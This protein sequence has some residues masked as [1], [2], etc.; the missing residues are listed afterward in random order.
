[1]INLK[2]IISS[3]VYRKIIVEVCR[4]SKI[5]LCEEYSIG[6]NK[7]DNNIIEKSG[8]AIEIIENTLKIEN[9]NFIKFCILKITKKEIQEE[10][11]EYAEGEELDGEEKSIFISSSGYSQG[12]LIRYLIEYYYLK[13]EIKD[14]ELYLKSIKIPQPKKYIKEL[15]ECYKKSQN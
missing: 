5:F 12:F 8:L 10:V 2:E 6:E 15:T 1:M 13:N 9:K 4:R 11:E 3:E 14:F 7:I